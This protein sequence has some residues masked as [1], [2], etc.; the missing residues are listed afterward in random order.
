MLKHNQPNERKTVITPI[1][2]SKISRD[3]TKQ[4][5]KLGR[6]SDQSYHVDEVPGGI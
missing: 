2:Q 6:I 1:E 3:G 4:D 5:V